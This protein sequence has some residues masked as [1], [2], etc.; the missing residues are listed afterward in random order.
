MLIP[1]IEFD[2]KGTRYVVEDTEENETLIFN[3]HFTRQ[4]K[5]T[6]AFDW[7]IPRLTACEPKFI[8]FGNAV[9]EAVDGLEDATDYELASDNE[10]IMA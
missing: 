6:L 9:L 5:Y 3:N 7:Q 10:D 1:V 4:L 8:A 2:H